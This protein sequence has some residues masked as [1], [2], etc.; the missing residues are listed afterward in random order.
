MTEIGAYKGPAASRF[1]N[2]CPETRRILADRFPAT[3]CSL[4]TKFLTSFNKKLYFDTIMVYILYSLA[5]SDSYY[6]DNV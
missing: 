1:P 6:E 5:C 3:I 2:K 4:I